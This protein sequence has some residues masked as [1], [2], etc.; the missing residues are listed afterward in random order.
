MYWKIKTTHKRCEVRNNIKKINDEKNGE[1]NMFIIGGTLVQERLKAE[2][3]Y[4]YE[5]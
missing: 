3:F 4:Y 1:F 5:W 2:Y